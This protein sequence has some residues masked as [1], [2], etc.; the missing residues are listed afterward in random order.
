[1]VDFTFNIF[2]SLLKAF[3]KTGYEVKSVQD[4]FKSS[5]SQKGRL[6]W[7]FTIFYSLFSGREIVRSRNTHG[8]FNQKTTK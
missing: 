2:K 6:R 4:Y 8:V 1:M 3:I 5:F 7:G